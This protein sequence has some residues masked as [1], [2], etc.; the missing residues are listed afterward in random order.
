MKIA[1]VCTGLLAELLFALGINVSRTRGSAKQ[2]GSIPDDPADP[3]FKAIRAHG[4]TAEYAPMIAVLMLYL[5]AHSPTVWIVWTMITSQPTRCCA[6][7][8]AA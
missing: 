1:V 2:I 8:N 3:L 4:N 5:G 7:R 6:G